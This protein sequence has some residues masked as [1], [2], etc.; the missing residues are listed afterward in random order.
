MKFDIL[1]ENILDTLNG[2]YVEQLTVKDWVEKVKR[3]LTLIK[4]FDELTDYIY[5]LLHVDLA[6]DPEAPEKEEELSALC[7]ELYGDSVETNPYLLVKA[8]QE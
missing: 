8:E 7:E 3:E 4:D 6:E 1:F 2:A 5:N